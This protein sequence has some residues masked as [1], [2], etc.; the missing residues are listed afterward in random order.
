MRIIILHGWGHSAELWRGI[1]QKLE[2][3]GSAE[4]WDLPGFGN[5]PLVSA[6]WGIAEYADWVSEKIGESS[7]EIV[8]I[9]HSFGGRVAS[10]LA[11]RKPSYLRAL[12]LIGAPC[13]YRPST[14]IRL[15]SAIASIVKPIVPASIRR[16]LIT[17]DLRDAEDSGIGRVFRN[18][19][20]NDQTNSLPMI[21]VPA[22]LLWGEND[23]AA[24]V[25]IAKEI[26]TLIPG[27]ML[28]VLPGIG[29]NVHID[30]PMLTYGA[31]ERFLEAL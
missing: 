8:L 18:A 6:A 26:Q 30:N 24:P 21:S 28:T 17:E 27:S 2:R 3:F 29:H 19:V 13:I 5:E 22:F 31:I 25:S 1:A 11:S 20:T 9:G 16:M 7:D 12:V 10:L 15:K 4:V 14:T 23:D